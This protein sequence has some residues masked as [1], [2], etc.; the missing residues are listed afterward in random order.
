MLNPD[1]NLETMHYAYNMAP[2][3]NM[4][5]YMQHI[6]HEQKVGTHLNIQSVLFDAVGNQI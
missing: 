5:T 4:S 1:Y 3:L 6:V 2:K